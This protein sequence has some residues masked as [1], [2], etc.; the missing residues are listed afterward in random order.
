MIH[1]LEDEA[2]AL[3][4]HAERAVSRA[5]GGSCT[6]PLAAYAERNRD[7]LTLRALV[8]SPDGRNVIRAE[9]EGADPLQLG[10]A[11]AADLRRQGADEILKGLP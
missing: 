3:C 8:A 10:N 5:L 9:R 6:L 2:T 7:L 11:V 1:S 4:V